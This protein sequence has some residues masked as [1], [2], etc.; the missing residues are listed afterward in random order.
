VT[1]TALFD[2]RARLWIELNTESATQATWLR[3]DSGGTSR[4][5][6]V[7]KQ[8]TIRAIVDDT[9]YGVWTGDLDVQTVRVYELVG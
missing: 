9:I 5:L 2:D 7:P 1:G 3:I 8:F 4:R 6:A